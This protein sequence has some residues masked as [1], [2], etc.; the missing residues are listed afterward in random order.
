MKV[1]I[2]GDKHSNPDRQWINCLPKDNTY[3]VY[4]IPLGNY[5]NFYDLLTHHIQEGIIEQYDH[6][7][8][9]SANEPNLCFYTASELYQCR[10]NCCSFSQ[11]SYSKLQI[12]AKFRAHFV[13]KAKLQNLR[14]KVDSIL[15]FHNQHA[16]KSTVK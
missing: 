10:K 8:I 12:S 15:I 14:M 6:V 5:L 13:H 7:V 4:F 3:T 2:Y 16:I 1:L 9:Q 11:F